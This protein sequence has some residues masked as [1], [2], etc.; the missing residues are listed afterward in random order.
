MSYIYLYIWLNLKIHKKLLWVTTSKKGNHRQGNEGRR[1]EDLH[2]NY[3]FYNH[4]L[5]S[6][7]ILFFFFLEKGVF[8]NWITLCRFQVYIIPFTYFAPPPAPTTLATTPAPTTLAT[9]NLLS[10]IY[11]FVFILSFLYVFC[12]TNKIMFLFFYISDL[13]HL[14]L[15]PS[16]YIRVVKNGNI[17]LCMAEY[18]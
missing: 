6:E 2:F 1:R 8:F 5:S 7:Y 15:I 9:T 10:V 14:A 16:R 11:E 4:N 3:T 13:F 18:I 12:S 17:Y